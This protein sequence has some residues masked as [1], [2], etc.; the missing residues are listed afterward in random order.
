MAIVLVV[1]VVVSLLL[2]RWLPAAKTLDHNESR[3]VYHGGVL[4]VARSAFTFAQ[5]RNKNRAE[6]SHL[7]RPVSATLR[8]LNY[9]VS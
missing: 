1:I 6:G 9:S 3:E 7:S 5:T 8:I 2:R 4:A